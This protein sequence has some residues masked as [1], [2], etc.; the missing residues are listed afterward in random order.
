MFR[1]GIGPGPA[2]SAHRTG[3]S[4]IACQQRGIEQAITKRLLGANMPALTA[5]RDG[6]PTARLLRYS[7]FTL[8]SNSSVLRVSQPDPWQA[9]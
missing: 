6:A 1:P 7:Q 4:L 8:L 3:R 2:I 5:S 9:D